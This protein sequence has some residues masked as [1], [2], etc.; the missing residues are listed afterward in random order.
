MSNFWDTVGEAAKSFGTGAVDVASALADHTWHGT[1]EIGS[2]LNTVTGGA[3]GAV[4]NELASGTMKDLGYLNDASNFVNRVGSTFLQVTGGSPANYLLNPQS[5]ALAGEHGR[6]GLEAAWRTAKHTSPGQVFATDLLESSHPGLNYDT[7]SSFGAHGKNYDP[8]FSNTSGTFDAVAAWYADPL[9]LAGKGAKTYKAYKETLR[10]GDLGKILDENATLTGRQQ[11]LRS[12]WQG[13]MDVTRD[14]NPAELY[15]LAFIRESSAGDTL[16]SLIGKANQEADPALR[17]AKVTSILRVGFGDTS[18]IDELRAQGDSLGDDLANMNESLDYLKARPD[19]PEIAPVIANLEAEVQRRQSYLNQLDRLTKAEHSLGSRLAPATH[20]DLLDNV[21]LS[22]LR[23]DDVLHDGITSKPVYISRW[24]SGYRPNGWVKLSD[25]QNVVSNVEK[26]L[27]RVKTL[28][29]QTRMRWLGDVINADTDAARQVAVNRLEARVFKHVGNQVDPNLSVDELRALYGESR[30]RRHQLLAKWSTRAYAGG[31][32]DERKNLDLQWDE[33]DG[34]YYARPVF[35]TQLDNEMPLIDVDHVYQSLRRAR[36][37]GAHIPV[38]N[39]LGELTGDGLDRYMNLWKISKLFRLGYALRSVGDAQ[40]RMASV[41]G[42]LGYWSTLAEGAK[43]YAFKNKFALGRITVPEMADAAERASAQLKLDLIDSKLRTMVEYDSTDAVP[44][45]AIP[46]P[47]TAGTDVAGRETAVTTG[48][49]PVAADELT[50]QAPGD[51]FGIPANDAAALRAHADQ[52]RARLAEPQKFETRRMTRNERAHMGVGTLDVDGTEVPDALGGSNEEFAYL[53]SL[54]DARESTTNLLDDLQSTARSALRT[55]GSFDV[56]DGLNKAYGPSW[57]RV[58]NG[59]IRNSPLAMRIIHGDHD[60]DLKRWLR[61]TPEGRDY[62]RRMRAMYHGDLDEMIG[63]TRATIEHTLGRQDELYLLAREREL[64][65]A[66]LKAAIPDNTQ[67]PTINAAVAEAT[68][69]DGLWSNFFEKVNEKFYRVMNDAPETVMGRHPLYVQLYRRRVRD[70]VRNA[71]AMSEDGLTGEQVNAI[72]QASRAWA[73]EEMKRTLFNIDAKSNLS[74]KTRFVFAFF[75]AWED[76]MHKY[77]RLVFQSPQVVP[78]AAML[79]NAPDKAGLTVDLNGN[80]VQGGGLSSNQFVLVPAIP[81]LRS[82]TSI[83]RWRISKGSVNIVLQG[84]PWWMP[85][86]SGLTGLGANEIAK[87]KPELAAEFQKVGMLPFGVQP[88]SKDFVDIVPTWGKYLWSSVHPS[89]QDYKETFSYIYATEA[90]RINTGERAKPKSQE[91]FLKEIASRTRN[92]YIARAFASGV[93]PVSASPQGENQFYFDKAHEYR[94]KYGPTWQQKFY[95]DF[96]EYYEATVSLSNSNTGVEATLPSWKA[97]KKYKDL[98]ARDPQFGWFVVG[99]E[100]DGDYSEAVRAAQFGQSVAPGSSEKFR[101]FKDPRAEAED[102]QAQ[103]G[104]IQ[105]QSMS[106]QLD[107]LQQKGTANADQVA[108]FKQAFV[109]KLGK[110]N[111]SWLNDYEQNQGSKLGE[112]LRFASSVVDDKRFAKRGDMQAVKTYFGIR[113]MVQQLLAQR[114][115]QGGASSLAANSNA[116][117]AKFW[118]AFGQAL[119]Q[120]Y[121]TF[122]DTYD[123]MLEHDDLTVRL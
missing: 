65:L 103:K 107:T 9:V 64:K 2:A 118:A 35:D 47:S 20:S 22:R 83:A 119:K 79:W 8:L 112:F 62:A 36:V 7:A 108:A 110:D 104:W 11:T 19:S 89:D 88:H 54:I 43:N 113:S 46:Q 100:G 39:D 16:A 3:A 77:G 52:L 60:T 101:D 121:V 32:A 99:E 81:G 28:D 70:A 67:W 123:R 12:K 95:D 24:L 26:M 72:S 74:H 18:H 82:L 102:I 34:M 86:W 75:S 69:N 44:R 48:G 45:R 41:L 91:A 80:I 117:V 76:T 120:R 40:I 111:P 85:G 1:E 17:D 116:D 13:L 68:F 73:R 38:I 29:P 122:G 87:R 61:G 98:I 115:A 94:D 5:G 53:R 6:P 14:K 59:Q 49:G 109:A 96:P 106:S 10:P 71:A 78:H 31:S 23:Y 21:R 33:A 105:Y 58:V 84:D 55:N 114:K 57:E 66:D 93:L 97:S 50:D 25:S 27:D 92:W 37:Q 30:N 90:M 42:G 63:R 15:Q 56:I 4:G 51:L